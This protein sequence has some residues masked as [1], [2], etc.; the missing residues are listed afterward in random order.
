MRRSAQFYAVLSR[1]KYW[2]RHRVRFTRRVPTL[3]ADEVAIKLVLDF[4]DAIWDPPTVPMVVKDEHVIRP[5]VGAS[6]LPPGG[7]E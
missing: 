4:D 3:G 2:P 5:K 7:R 6:A 1:S